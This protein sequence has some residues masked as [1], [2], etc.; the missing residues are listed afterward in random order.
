M[1]PITASLVVFV[2]AFGG[3]LLGIF[4]H[5]R[6]PE[7]HL[8]GE[9]K[10][11][12]KLGMALVSTTVA[13]VL[14]LLVSS[15]KGFYDTQNAEVTQLSTN[16]VLLDRL[17]AHYGPEAAEARSTLRTGIQ[18]QIDLMWWRDSHTTFS[19]LDAPQNEI[20]LDKIQELSPKEDRQRALQAQALNL[21]I[22]LG[23]VRLL[24]FQQR[25]VPIPSLLLITLVFWLTALFISF[26]LFA[27]LNVTV[28]ASQFIAAVAVC[29]AIYLILEFYYPYSGLIQI[30]DA[31]LRAALAQLAK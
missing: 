13:L 12:V 26:G 4:I 8:S 21:A 29:A 14:G 15:A 17:L 3:A 9:T 24:M 22:Q 10:D 1:N 2:C 18:A 20:L 11:V 27:P 28:V 31:P 5:R 16:I 6:L 23:Q 30:S 19:Q 25:R 7:D